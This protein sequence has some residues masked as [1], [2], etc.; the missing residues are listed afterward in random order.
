MQKWGSERVNKEEKVQVRRGF[1]NHVPN[2]EWVQLVDKIK[3]CTQR[4]KTSKHT[5]KWGSV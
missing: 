4:F 5:D 2:N 3:N 1:W